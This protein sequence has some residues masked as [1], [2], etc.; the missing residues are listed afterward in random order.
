MFDGQF[1]TQVDATVKPIGRGLARA[2]VTPDV[3]TCIGLVM[4]LAAAIAIGAG[5]FSLGVL[6]VALTGIPDLLDG[7][8]AKAS[9][10]SSVRGAFFDSVA[11]RVT[12]AMLFAALAFNFASTGEPAWVVLLPVA[13]YA[14]ASWVSYVRAKADA[15]GFDAHVGLVER[16]ERI[17]LLVVGLLFGG[18][19]L[20]GVL[21]AIVALNILTAAQRFAAVWSQATDATPTLSARRDE[22]RRRRTPRTESSAATRRAQRAERRRRQAESRRS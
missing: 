4:S 11:D 10:R 22:R 8:V 17:I 9:G 13:G 6:L 21:I 20:V 1:R 5:A 12:D 7:A 3:I 18:A 2:G 16:A 19:V 14:T 15:L